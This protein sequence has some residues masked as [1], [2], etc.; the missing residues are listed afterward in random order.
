HVH[1]H[2][3]ALVGAGS[4]VRMLSRIPGAEVVELDAGCCGMAGSFGFESEHYDLSMEIGGLRLLPAPAP[5]GEEL[6][7]AAAGVSCRQ[8]IA[9]GANRLARHPVELVRDAL[10]EDRE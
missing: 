4:A 5:G 6:A 7:V 2:E 9:H 1:C 3:R 10:G 8:Q